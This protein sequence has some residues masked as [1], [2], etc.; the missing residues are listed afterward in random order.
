MY[1]HN[2]YVRTIH[3]G[4]VGRD[5]PIKPAR[6]RTIKLLTSNDNERRERERGPFPFPVDY[7]YDE[8]TPFR[9]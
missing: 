5:I 2:L 3:D 1:T 4:D 8:S 7:Y 6:H 9:A